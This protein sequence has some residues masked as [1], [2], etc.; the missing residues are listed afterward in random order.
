MKIQIPEPEES[1]SGEDTSTP[2]R[3]VSVAKHPKN[4]LYIDS[5]A[6]LHIIFNRELLGGL[7]KLDRAIKIQ[8]GGKLIHLSKIGSLH[9]NGYMLQEI[10]RTTTNY[11]KI[12]THQSYGFVSYTLSP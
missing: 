8:A 9:K 10:Y 11:R 6:S 4:P 3:L 1:R 5:D 12:G 7:I 2:Q